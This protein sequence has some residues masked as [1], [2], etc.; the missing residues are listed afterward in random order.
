MYTE[1][2]KHAVRAA[3]KRLFPVTGAMY[4][5][6][7]TDDG[8]VSAQEALAEQGFVV[9]STVELERLRTIADQ[10]WPDV[11]R[12]NSLVQTVRA[13]HGRMED[14]IRRLQRLRDEIKALGDMVRARRNSGEVVGP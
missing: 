9:I 13:P 12:L 5:P 3:V 14:T 10:Y 6:R 8:I 4:A 1:Q 7:I 2:L 11:E